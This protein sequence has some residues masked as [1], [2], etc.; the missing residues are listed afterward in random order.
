VS[1]AF[2]R[3]CPHHGPSIFHRYG[4]GRVRCKRSSVTPSPDGIA[5]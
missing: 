4:D 3:V 2:E 1:T 5:E